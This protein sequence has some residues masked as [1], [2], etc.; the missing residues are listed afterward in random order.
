ML[1]IAQAR[2]TPVPAVEQRPRPAVLMMDI[3]IKEKAQHIIRAGVDRQH[4]F[5]EQLQGPGECSRNGRDASSPRT[6]CNPRI[7]ISGFLIF[8][9]KLCQQ[10]PALQR[11]VQLFAPGNIMIINIRQEN[12]RLSAR[13]SF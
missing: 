10:R 6:P 8:L 2:V 7:A 12:A 11:R 13:K 5:T 1:R 4:A 9:C 3:G